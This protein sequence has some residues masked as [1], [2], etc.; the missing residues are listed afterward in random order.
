MLEQSIQPTQPLVPHDMAERSLLAPK[1]DG[2][3]P[4]KE[5]KLQD[6]G[7]DEFLKGKCEEIDKD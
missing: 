2:F 3:E 7:Y 4:K 1:Q 6:K 5:V